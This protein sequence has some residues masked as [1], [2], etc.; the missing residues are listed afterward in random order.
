VTTEPFS[1]PMIS[2]LSSLQPEIAPSASCQ[3]LCADAAA[4]PPDPGVR[5]GASTLDS[6]ATQMTAIT[7]IGHALR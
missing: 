3:Q 2:P 1:V 7:R 5:G 4:D 6:V